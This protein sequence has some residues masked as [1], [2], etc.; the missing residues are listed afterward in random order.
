MVEIEAGDTVEAFRLIKGVKPIVSLR[1]ATGKLVWIGLLPDGD[2]SSF[3]K[4][5]GK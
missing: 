4:L 5:T 3:S 1:E 2:I